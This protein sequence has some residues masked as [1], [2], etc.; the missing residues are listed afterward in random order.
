MT[1]VTKTLPVVVVAAVL[2][3]LPALADPLPQPKPHALAH[4]AI[5]IVAR[6]ASRPEAR[7]VT[8]VDGGDQPFWSWA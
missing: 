1:A 8:N 6:S 7:K 4:M 2:A 5:S 3:C